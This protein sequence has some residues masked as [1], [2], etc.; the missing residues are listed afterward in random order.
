[1]KV[2]NIILD[3]KSYEENF[4]VSYIKNL[5]EKQK[6]EISLRF[7]MFILVLMFLFC[8][9]LHFRRKKN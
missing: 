1:M 4:L 5:D 8:L 9:I 2:H 7:T 6:N 3:F